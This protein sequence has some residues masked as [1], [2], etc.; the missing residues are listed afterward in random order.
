MLHR[1]VFVRGTRNRTLA[2]CPLATH[3]CQVLVLS[4]YKGFCC[5]PCEC[6]VYKDD[7]CFTVNLALAKAKIDIRQH[8]A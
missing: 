6:V 5:L 7:F 1:C 8:I 2:S 4:R 3:L